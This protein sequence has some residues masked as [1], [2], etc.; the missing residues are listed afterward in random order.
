MINNTS[1]K[2][3]LILAANPKT[4]SR[5]RLDEEVRQIDHGLK[6]SDR[7]KLEQ[8][9][10][11][12]QRD[13]YRA[14]LEYKPQIIHFCGHSEGDDGI[15]L[16]SEIGQ[17]VRMGTEALSRL[18][19]LFAVLGVECVVLNACYSEVQAEAISQYIK[20]VVGMNK[21]IGDKAAINFAVAFYDALA[22]GEDVQ[23]AYDLG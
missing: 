22:V 6:N 11:V 18:F 12:R 10:A 1:T 5:L 17:S 3:I 21:A 19:K 15:V 9:W 14:I 13:F 8:K 4:T 20:Y 7:F 2:T 23:F 16:D